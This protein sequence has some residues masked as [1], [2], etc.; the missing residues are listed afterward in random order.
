MKQLIQFY[1][2]MNSRK[3]KIKTLFFLLQ[4]YIKKKKDFKEENCVKAFSKDILQF[5][6]DRHTFKKL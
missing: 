1:V 5:D 3:K 2:I 6:N 4:A